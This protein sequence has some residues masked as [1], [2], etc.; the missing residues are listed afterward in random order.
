MPLLRKPP[1]AVKAGTL[2][3]L[4]GLLFSCGRGAK[5]ADSAAPAG[6]PVRVIHP[7]LTD[8]TETIDLNANTLFLTREAV[9]A[10]FQGFIEKT[11]RTLG[12]DVKA[13][14][15]LFAIRTRESAADDSLAVRLGLR[16]GGAPFSGSV[17]IRAQTDGVLTSQSF[18]TGD[19]VSDGEQIATV[20]NPA[21]LRIALNVPFAFV[22]RIRRAEGCTLMFPDG[23]VSGAH[24]QRTLPSVDSESQTQTFILKPD[25]DI[26]LPENLNVI[27]RLPLQTAR[28]APGVPKG[29]VMSDETQ[30]TFWIMKLINDSTA[31]RFDAVKGIENDSLIQIVRP[32]LRPDDRVVSEGAYGLPDTASVSLVG[33]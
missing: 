31:V 1:A 32:P 18:H 28:R 9:R 12:E 3:L 29:A 24:I 33:K 26:P 4:A 25:A 10:T 13:G 7:V 17:V 5:E 30:E 16:A 23:S 21:S 22:R 11:F 14:E 19:F 15:P 6:T 2:L 27:V 8:F 20:S